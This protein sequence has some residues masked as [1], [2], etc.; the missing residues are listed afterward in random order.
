MAQKKSDISQK[1]ST[2]SGEMKLFFAFFLSCFAM[3]C[4][5]AAPALRHKKLSPLDPQELSEVVQNLRSMRLECAFVFNLKT[6]KNKKVETEEGRFYFQKVSNK[7][8]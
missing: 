3:I 7:V 4:C 1:L 2:K 8:N 6:T 5:N